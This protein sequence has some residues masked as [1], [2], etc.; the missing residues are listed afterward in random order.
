MLGLYIFLVLTNLFGGARSCVWWKQGCPL[1]QLLSSEALQ[2][3]RHHALRDRQC[4]C[5]VWLRNTLMGREALCPPW[6]SLC[7]EVP[8]QC[9][10]APKVLREG[11]GCCLSLARV[12]RPLVSPVTFCS[13]GH[14]C[15]GVWRS[16]PVEWEVPSRG[17]VFC[18][19]GGII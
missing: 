2:P 8:P 16:A 3:C 14:V 13:F 12:G 11:V 18:V 1:W 15:W 17:A 7:W 6:R 5:V 4:W 9:R 19:L 10:E